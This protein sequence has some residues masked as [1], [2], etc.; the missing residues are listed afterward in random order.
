MITGKL[1]AVYWL[2]AGAVPVR[3][4]GRGG[5]GAC[6]P[7]GHASVSSDVS[8]PDCAQ[9]G[10][11]AV[12]LSLPPSLLP[13]PSL[14]SDH[15]PT[16]LRHTEAD[17]GMTCAWRQC[18][19]SRDSAADGINGASSAIRRFSRCLPLCQSVCLSVRP[20]VHLSVHPSFVQH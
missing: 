9:P 17:T 20:A 15:G 14:D 5:G 10:G 18:C 12:A 7:E 13:F 11:D 3:S 19:A 16:G 6:H 1:T 4:V 8:E 2:F